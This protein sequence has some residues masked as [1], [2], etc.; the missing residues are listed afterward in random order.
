MTFAPTQVQKGRHEGSAPASRNPILYLQLV[1]SAFGVFA[2]QALGESLTAKLIASL[3]T[4]TVLSFLTA[5]SKDRRRR[6]VLVAL[7]LA[8]LYALRRRPGEQTSAD[9]R[10]AV[11]WAPAS[12]ATIGLTAVAGFGV[13][14]AATTAAGNWHEKTTKTHHVV[15]VI[16]DVRGE[17]KSAAV[18]RL[19]E[20]GFDVSTKP[21]HSPSVA[22]RRALGTHPPTHSKLPEGSPVTVF[23]SNGPREVTVPSVA[24]Q[25]QEE[26][27][28]T[29]RDEDL[30]VTVEAQTSETV[31]EGTALR[32]DP[33]AGSRVPVGSPVKLVVS[34]GH[35]EVTVPAVLGE[36]E[37][38]AT[39]ELSEAFLSP[40]TVETHDPSPEGTVIGTNPPAG[41]RVVVG[42]SI[43]V[44]VSE[45][46]EVVDVDCPDFSSQEEAQEFFE[47][48]GGPE[49]DP[50]ELDRDHD[51]LACE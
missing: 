22:E 37:S 32:T 26:A 25:T 21:R 39:T 3:L 7:L 36:T 33:S 16:P 1:A 9:G 48:H 15:V 12:W 38:E 11:A 46:P 50:F 6:I 31:P 44:V 34:K 30:E 19:E 14:S 24:G 2:A 41:E 4:T 8:L 5:E 45:G 17:M 13:G 20:A 27:K 47:E 10:R 29:L 51:E 49:E 28:T 43:E 42:S 23:V 40:F 18:K 35:R